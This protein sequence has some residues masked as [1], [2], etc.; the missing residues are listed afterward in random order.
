MCS[1]KFEA[2]FPKILKH[3]EITQVKRVICRKLA[4]TKQRMTRMKNSGIAPQK[5]TR[6]PD[7][8]DAVSRVFNALV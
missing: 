5:T 7:L 1:R 8:P 2:K 3:P 6:R 4:P